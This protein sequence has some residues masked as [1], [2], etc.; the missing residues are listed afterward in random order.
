MVSGTF[1]NSI[2][3]Y[4]KQWLIPLNLFNLEFLMVSPMFGLGIIIGNE[5]GK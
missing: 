4:P 3:A 2:L 1:S 5:F